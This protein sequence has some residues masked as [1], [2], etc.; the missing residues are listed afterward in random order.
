MVYRRMAFQFLCDKHKSNPNRKFHFEIAKYRQHKPKD[1][2]DTKKLQVAGTSRNDA[3]LI[4]RGFNFHDA[5]CI[6]S[7]M[8]QIYHLAHYTCN[9][10]TTFTPKPLQNIK[11][12]ATYTFI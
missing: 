9:T 3:I 5:Y 2:P 1:S 7:Y 4:F 10:Y 8:F 6:P 11:H 12:H